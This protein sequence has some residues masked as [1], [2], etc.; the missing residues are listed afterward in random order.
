MRIE[1]LFI[2]RTIEITSPFLLSGVLT[3]LILAMRTIRYLSL[4]IALICIPIL[5]SAQ[6]SYHSDSTNA[7]DYYQPGRYL[8]GLVAFTRF[9]PVQPSYAFEQDFWWMSGG[10]LSIIRRTSERLFWSSSLG[11]AAASL[12]QRNVPDIRNTYD[13]NTGLFS[14]QEILG[15]R[16]EA[17]RY[18]YITLPVDL[19]YLLFDTKGTNICMS[20]GV[21]L[22]WL[23]RLNREINA[24][25]DGRFDELTGA[26]RFSD[27]SATARAGI[28]LYQPL[29]E[30][31]V[32]IVGPTHGYSFYSNYERQVQVRSSRFTPSVDF[33]FMYRID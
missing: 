20:G 21:V 10:G 2:I 14:H 9:S 6:R 13:P 19:H 23:Y 7:V 1:Y 3:K 17:W 25:Y 4:G 16:D 15:T 12:D 24:T 32:M 26:A 28:G 33:R 31:L 30:H 11:Y 18:H 5:S 29:G 27:V 8:V 22:D